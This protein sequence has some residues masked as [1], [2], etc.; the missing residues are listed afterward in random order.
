LTGDAQFDKLGPVELI[1]EVFLEGPLR[2]IFA[3]MLLCVGSA[4]VASAVFTTPEIDPGSGVN[5][6]A[7]ISAAVLI[8]RGRRRK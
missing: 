2:K 5:A 7:L 4:A 6:I 8:Y 3:V 1:V